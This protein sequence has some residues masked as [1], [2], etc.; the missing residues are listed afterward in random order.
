MPDADAKT[1]TVILGEDGVKVILQ[2][3]PRLSESTPPSVFLKPLFPVGEDTYEEGDLVSFGVEGA[4]QLRMEL[5]EFLD[6]H[7]E[8]AG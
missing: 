6:E 1:G 3:L 5:D 7:A 8:E 4:R 2:K